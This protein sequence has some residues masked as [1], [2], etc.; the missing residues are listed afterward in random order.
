MAELNRSLPAISLAVVG[1][2]FP[3]ADG[4][5]RGLEIGKCTPGEPVELRAEPTNK[6][7]PRAVA[8]FSSRG[9]QIG[10]LTAERCGW[11]GSMLRSGREINAVF[12]A[13]SDFG[14]WIRVAFDGSAPILPAQ[15]QRMPIEPEGGWFPD[16]IWPDD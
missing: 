12:Q 4:S 10:Y 7:D 11:I 13:D 8:V 3:N 1:G 2:P 14:A 5:S 9:V 15:R 16:E 6:H